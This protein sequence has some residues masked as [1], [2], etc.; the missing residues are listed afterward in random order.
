MMLRYQPTVG[1][2]VASISTAEGLARFPSLDVPSFCDVVEFRVDLYP[3]VVASIAE[4]A[5]ANTLPSLI[6]VRDA[7][8][9][10]G[11]LTFEQRLALSMV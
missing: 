4:T 5:R 6:T 10:G 1:H 9:G 11:Q 3:E 8:E 7:K 2:V